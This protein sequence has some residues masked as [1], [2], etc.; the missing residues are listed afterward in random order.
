MQITFRHGIV[1]GE[2][3][4][5]GNPQ[6]LTLTSGGVNL[7]VDQIDFVVAFAHGGANYLHQETATVVNAWSGPFTPGVDTHLYIDINLQTGVRTFGKTTITPSAG[8]S[9][10]A[11]PVDDKHWF[12]TGK[13]TMK[14]YKTNRWVDTVRMFVGKVELGAIL[15]MSQFGST[16]G[17]SGGQHYAGFIM[18]DDEMKPIKKF[19]ALNA[20]KFIT[21]ETPLASQ[22]HRSANFRVETG[23]QTAQALEFI[24][25]WSP[26][27]YKQPNKI[28]I[29]KSTDWEFPAVGIA[30]E[31]MSPGEVNTIV[32][33]GY[34]QDASWD[35]TESPNTPI[36]VS[37]LGAMTTT[38]PQQ[39]SVMQVATIVDP[40]RILVKIEETLIYQ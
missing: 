12:D 5:F 11:T 3:D 21:T 23:I 32:T 26:V 10:P 30:V 15:R 4:T 6:F 28:G 9:P 13:T 22:L 2:R 35:W 14:V 31:D 27:C 33:A 34:V 7:Y 1:K 16:V 40:N 29:A 37:P 39:F 38:P 36:F 24:P 18:F 20:G 8:I 17:I 25:K 19:D